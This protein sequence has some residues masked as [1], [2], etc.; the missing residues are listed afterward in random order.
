L[1]VSSWPVSDGP[2]PDDGDPFIVFGAHVGRVSIHLPDP[3]PVFVTP[4][5]A[6]NARLRLGSAINAA[7][8]ARE[9]KGTT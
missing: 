3:G 8:D 5:G 2:D 7:R 9:G 1:S 6:E 4:E